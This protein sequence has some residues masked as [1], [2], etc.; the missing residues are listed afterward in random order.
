HRNYFTDSEKLC[1]T[2]IPIY[3]VQICY[4][5]Q[6]SVIADLGKLIVDN[7]P[8]MLCTGLDCAVVTERNG[9]QAGSEL[10]GI[11]KT[12]HNGKIIL[13]LSLFLLSKWANLFQSSF[14]TSR[15][16]T[17]LASIRSRKHCNY[18]YIC[19]QQRAKKEI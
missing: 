13:G 2:T 4:R 3:Y 7:C 1:V 11:A 12:K 17:K 16:S 6:S 10:I 5:S 8:P 9:C 15:V 14:I 18:Y 19:V